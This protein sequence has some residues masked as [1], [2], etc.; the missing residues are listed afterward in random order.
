MHAICLNVNV[1]INKWLKI[2][3]VTLLSVSSRLLEQH[4]YLQSETSQNKFV[5]V[6]VVGFLAEVIKCLYHKSYIV[7]VAVTLDAT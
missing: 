7:V 1:Y 5:S 4:I 3:C 6:C 2:G